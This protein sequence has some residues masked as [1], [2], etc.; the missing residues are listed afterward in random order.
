MFINKSFGDSRL[1]YTKVGATQRISQI[2]ITFIFMVFVFGFL[3]R[4]INNQSINNYEIIITAI[5]FTI[6][7]GMCL[8]YTE[9]SI[10]VQNVKNV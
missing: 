5:L 4:M 10:N 1:Q 3:R 7:Y 8:I 2:F 6:W 9:F